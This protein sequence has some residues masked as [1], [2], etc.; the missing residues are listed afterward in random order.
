MLAFKAEVESQCLNVIVPAVT[1]L[2]FCHFRIHHMMFITAVFKPVM[3]E[4][5]ESFRTAIKLLRLIG[6]IGVSSVSGIRSEV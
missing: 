5:L 6:E 2:L 1:L 3:R 4:M